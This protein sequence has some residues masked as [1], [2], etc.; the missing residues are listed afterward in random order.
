MA[1][2]TYTNSAA[3]DLVYGMT[4]ETSIIVTALSRTVSAVKSEVRNA[5]NDVC[6]VSYSGLTGAISIEGYVNGSVSMNVATAI[7]LTNDMTSGGLS[8]GTIIVDSYA[9]SQAQGEFKKLSIS[10]TQY[11]ESMTEQA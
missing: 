1:A 9:E 5:A 6:A 8:G 10:A 3:A 2:T 7:T 4:D 11:S